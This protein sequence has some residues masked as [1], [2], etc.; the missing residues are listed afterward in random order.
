[1]VQR[2]FGKYQPWFCAVKGCR[3]KLMDPQS[4]KLMGKGWKLATTH[5]GIAQHM[6][7]PCKCV[8]KHVPCEG[9]LTRMTAY[10]TE[11]FARRVCRAILWDKVTPLM[12]KELRGDKRESY[13]VV[14]RPKECTCDCVRHPKSRLSCNLCE[15]GAEM[16]EGLSMVGNDMD[17]DAEESLTEEKKDR[18]LKQIAMLHRN[19]GHGPL[20]H[21]VRALEARGTGARVV[22]LAKGYECAV[23]KELGRQ[24]P[25]PRATLEPL[26]P[27]WA[28]IQADVAYW[29]HPKTGERCQFAIII[30][31]GCRFRVGKMMV[32][33]SGGVN[34]EQSINC[35]R[36]NWKPAFGK[37]RKLRADPGGPWRS[38]R[39]DEYFM[40]EQVELDTIPAEAHW[41]FSHVERAIQCTKHIMNKLAM[42][43]HNLSA[44]EALSEAIRIEN[45]R[46]V[47]RGFSPAQH[48][49]GRAADEHGRITPSGA[50]EV[51][52]VLVDDPQGEFGRT[53]EVMREAEKAMTDYVYN[54]RLRRAQNTRPHQVQN[55]QPGDLVFVWRIQNNNGNRGH[56]RGGFTGPCRILATET[57]ETPEGVLYPSSVVW[58]V[59]GY[60]LLKADTR[61]LRH[62]THR[63]ECVEQLASPVDLP[64][65]MTKLTEE[66][67]GRQYE[68]VSNEI[69]EAME[70]EAARDEERAAP[71]RRVRQKRYVHNVRLQVGEWMPKHLRAAG[72]T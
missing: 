28:T 57:R 27:K 25:R 24:V 46:E 60:R 62:A 53:M 71:P 56:R 11:D 36:E 47:V 10:Y 19:T 66:L 2:V 15:Y 9:K 33:G 59:R 3:V 69:P 30:D 31:E 17:V 32:K 49:L 29:V 65:T 34:G 67:G 20:E 5:P 41:G 54:D 7:L 21:L 18:C 50:L 38:N 37:P 43:D 70:M 22:A 6:D 1:M 14:R 8:E 4:K 26:P 42:G 35:Y 39:V 72:D 45:E 58:L 12:F 40:G 52:P 61:Q 51:P 55:Y 64:W 68:D 13:Q 63:E 48:A 44:E 16:V 23:C